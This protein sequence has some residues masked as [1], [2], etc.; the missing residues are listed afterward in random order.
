MSYTEP[1]SET[2]TLELNYRFENNRNN[3]ERNT[4]EGGVN[5]AGKSTLM[6]IIAGELDPSEG[7]MIRNKSIRIGHLAQDPVPTLTCSISD[8]LFSDEHPALG[9]IKRYEEVLENPEG[10][11]DEINQLT[12]ELS[13][14]DAWEYEHKIKQILGILGIHH[15]KQAINTLSGGQKKRIALAKLLI[16]DPDLYILDEPTNHLDIDTI[17]WL[18]EYL[19]K[20]NKTLIMVTHDRYFLDNVCNEIIEID[21]GSVFPYKGTYSYY[22][23][24]KS[25]REEMDKASYEKNKNLWRKELEWMRRQPKARTTKSKARIDAF[26]DLDEKT[27]T[28]RPNQEVELSIKMSTQGNKILELHHVAKAYDNKNIINDINTT[29]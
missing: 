26:S 9:L 15:L 18:E 19:N 3:A 20:G 5:G 4:L 13:A 17:E 12:D 25:E 27:K 14:A 11:E 6:N 10:R 21:R 22:L 29:K 24:K 28:L 2:T 8:Y 23:E 7:K 1:L 16:E